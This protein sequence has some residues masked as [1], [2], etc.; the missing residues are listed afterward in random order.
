MNGRSYASWP[1]E[2]NFC[3]VGVVLDNES[4]VPR[5]CEYD[6]EPDEIEEDRGGGIMVRVV[7]LA[8]DWLGEGNMPSS[9]SGPET[10]IMDKVDED[11]I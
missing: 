1:V 3:A 5:E 6:E 11:G 10:E 8:D 4:E 7:S 9:A 2:L